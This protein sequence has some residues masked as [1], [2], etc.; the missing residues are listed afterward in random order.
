[1]ELRELVED[2]N[3]NQ[4]KLNKLNKKLEMLKEYNTKIT[5]SYGHNNGG[6]KGSVSSKVER[7]AL[8]I[9]E[10]EQMRAEFQNYVDL[11]DVSTKVLNK[12]ELQVIEL[13][14]VHKNKLSKIAKELNTNKKYIFDTRNR[15]LK[16]MREYINN[17]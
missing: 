7:H 4:N 12:K 3:S 17:I 6:G 8:K 9:Y 16:K 13:V 10:T 14:K 1:M 5:A 11:V 15:A 2:Y